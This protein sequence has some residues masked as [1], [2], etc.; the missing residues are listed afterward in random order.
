M[1]TSTID[2]PQTPPFRYVDGLATLDRQARQ[3]RLS[4]ELADGQH[5]YAGAHAG[6][7]GY[8]L[9]EAMAQACGVLLR[10]VTVGD[11]GGLLVG[12]DQAQLPEQVSFPARLCV[13]VALQD[14]RPPFFNFEARVDAGTELVACARLQVMTKREFA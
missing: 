1:N 12:I 2:L 9:I 4:L 8:L 6:L 10:G 5:R 14:S 11:N 3:A 7:Q 13:S